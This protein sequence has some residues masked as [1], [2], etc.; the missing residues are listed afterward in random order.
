M[1]KALFQYDI[2]TPILSLDYQSAGLIGVGCLDRVARVFDANAPFKQLG[3]TKNDSMPISSVNFYKDDM[4]F[5]A[6]TDI[7]K[8]WNISDEIY[9]T[10]NI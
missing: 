6:G 2:G 9:L 5:T 4:M 3:Q 8:A 1:C 7:L 10:D